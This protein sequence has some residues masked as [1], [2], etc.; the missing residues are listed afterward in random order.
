MGQ[1]ARCSLGGFF[2]DP[3]QEGCERE[4]P[5]TMPPPSASVGER[6]KG[7]GAVQRA[8]RGA[9]CSPAAPRCQAP[10]GRYLRKPLAN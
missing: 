8:G 10:G 2:C 7:K 5:V 9:I 3:G 1:G 4:G 6:G